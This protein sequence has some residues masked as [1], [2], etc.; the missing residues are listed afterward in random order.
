MKIL[1]I[2]D[3][4]ELIGGSEVY[5]LNLF[6]ILE[7]RGHK[8]IVIY[9]VKAKLDNRT[10][11]R[12][13]YFVSFSQPI[14]VIVDAIADIIKK[15]SP[16]IIH[17]HNLGQAQGLYS[18]IGELCG[19][20]PVV[21]SVHEHSVYCPSAQKYFYNGPRICQRK[22]GLYCLFSMLLNRCLDS[23]RPWV[24]F[25]FYNRPKQFLKN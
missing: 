24:S 15:E 9:G 20:I 12:P 21:Q 8:V 17:I 23:K 1:M 16:D 25:D 7:E 13:S 4:Y 14:R 2:N 5:L 18:Y 22:Y 6:D 10:E 11:H 19:L 3:L